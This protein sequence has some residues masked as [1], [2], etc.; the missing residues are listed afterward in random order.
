VRIVPNLYPIV[1]G[2]NAGRGT[3]G[4]HEVVI[5]CPDHRRSF[6]N[7]DDDEAAEVLLAMRDRAREQL[8][9]GHSYVAVLI[10]H[11][12]AAGA[13]IAHPHGQLV[14]LDFLPVEVAESLA[15]VARRPDH[16][17]VV[18]DLG[19]DPA[20]VV[21]DGAAPAWCP[22]G[23]PT[24]F[25]IRVAHPHAGPSFE[26]ANDDHVIA[27]AISLRDALSRLGRVTGDDV[28]YNLVVHTVP[29]EAGPFHWYAEITPRISVVAG[30]EMVTG[31]LVNTTPPETAAE[32]LRNAAP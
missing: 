24:P 2:T 16:D 21:T 23:S 11:G 32:L 31:L 20:L 6:G 14:A 30:F 13:S 1:G 18:E 4:A 3:T 22:W 17:L 7:L 10:N 5:M 27:A 9:A 19:R 12:R 8:R 29:P 15:R 28:A 25:T 26:D